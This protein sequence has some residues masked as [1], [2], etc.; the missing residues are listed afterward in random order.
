M[1]NKSHSSS[2]P[3]TEKEIIEEQQKNKICKIYMYLRGQLCGIA[4]GFFCLIPYPDQDHLIPALITANRCINEQLLTENKEIK[5]SLNNDKKKLSIKLNN[6]RKIYTSKE[7]DTTIIEIKPKEDKIHDYF[8]LDD[9][10]L[11]DNLSDIYNQSKIY[12]VC[13]GKDNK[14]DMYNGTIKEIEGEEI[15]H[16]SDLI[17]GSGGCPI[18]SPST[19]KVIGLH[20]GRTNQEHKKGIFMNIPLKEF[21]SEEKFLKLS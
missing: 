13:Y 16:I 19:Y 2:K 14:M 12:F 17:S 1:G 21:I 3:L 5:I 20:L 18:L 6:D 8:E 7:H 9:N 11:K 10:L 4:N 15:H